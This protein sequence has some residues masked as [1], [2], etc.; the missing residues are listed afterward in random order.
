MKPQADAGKIPDVQ[1]TSDYIVGVLE[2][3]DRKE[4]EAKPVVK[5]EKPKPR[6]SKDEIT[7]NEFKRRTGRELQPGWLTEKNPTNRKIVPLSKI[8]QIGRKR[9]AER[10]AWMRT[11]PDLRKELEDVAAFLY[12][13]DRDLREKAAAKIRKL[14]KK[15]NRLAGHDWRKPKPKKIT[16]SG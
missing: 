5:R 3:M 14:I 4:A 1:A 2:R 10:L 12:S 7:A 15:S 11:K 9:L 6:L 16:L 13:S 8:E